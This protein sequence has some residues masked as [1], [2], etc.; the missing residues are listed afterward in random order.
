MI[1]HR[2][3]AC[4]SRAGA[5]EFAY[6]CAVIGKM[7]NSNFIAGKFDARSHM[8]LGT[9]VEFVFGIGLIRVGPKMLVELRQR[10][11]SPIVQRVARV[12]VTIRFCPFI[13]ESRA[14][15]SDV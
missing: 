6:R 11:V 12:L 14:E 8:Q 3:L 1:S 5:T 7:Q 9:S 13:P 2:V 4:R 10:L 15:Y